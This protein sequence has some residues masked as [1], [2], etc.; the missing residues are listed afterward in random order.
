[1]NI[2]RFELRAQRSSFIIWGI[3]LLVTL[4]LFMSGM[5]PLFME[6]KVQVMSVLEGYPKAFA[7]AFGF[8]IDT[9]FSF[10]G[11][12]NFVFNYLGLVGGIMASGLAISVF[13][14][15]KKSKCLDFL[16]TKPVS[17]TK[18]FFIKLASCM[19]IIVVTN[20]IFMAGLTGIYFKQES[21]GKMDEKFILAGLSLFFL[22]LV[23]LSLGI[24]YGTFAK[25]I[26]TVSGIATSFGIFA[27]IMSAIVNILEKEELYI[28]APLKYFEPMQI[29]KDGM[30]EE[31]YIVAALI[32][33]IGGI[34]GA[35]LKYC[36]HDVH[37]V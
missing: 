26:R 23:F 2:A 14:R 37:A 13:A 12:Y 4:Y 15:E 16:L 8:Q 34:G 11:F 5:F 32:V 7:L 22:Q 28:L 31:K 24:F 30:Y 27:F 35:Y 20:V 29:F 3:S 36:R 19:L 18:V 1:M 33:V 17:R 25:K 9:L 10:R 6:S 21:S